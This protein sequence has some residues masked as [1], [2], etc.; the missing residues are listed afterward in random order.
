[1]SA[2]P[3]LNKDS[4]RRLQPTLRSSEE[5][6]H[7][8][9]QK[10]KPR[11]KEMKRPKIFARVPETEA[12]RRRPAVLLP[13][14]AHFPPA[15]R[16]ILCFSGSALELA[17]HGA[18]T[19]HFRGRGDLGPSTRTRRADGGLPVGLPPAAP[20]PAPSPLQ[21]HRPS[22][23]VRVTSPWPLTKPAYPLRR[24]SSSLLPG[25]QPPPTLGMPR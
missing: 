5:F 1:M 11:H 7:H 10:R 20:L 14:S 9:L 25:P 4:E 22:W 19:C 8:L 17:S 18:A 2:A 12:C 3:D 16:E 6:N 24:C 15:R 21:G 23:R 13:G